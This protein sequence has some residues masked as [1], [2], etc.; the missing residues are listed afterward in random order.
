MQSSPDGSALVIVERSPSESGWQARLFHRTTFGEKA[1]GVTIPLPLE[2]TD[3]TDFTVSSLGQRSFAYIIARSP[4]AQSLLS[5]SLRISRVEAEFLL[6]E[7]K[8]KRNHSDCVVTA[9]NSFLDCF[10]EVWERFPVISA[11]SR[12]VA[13]SQK[14]L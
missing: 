4:S 14:G 13:S 2:F 11:I 6:R 1:D 5:I 8:E 7:Q 12:W 3:A 10:A 9:H